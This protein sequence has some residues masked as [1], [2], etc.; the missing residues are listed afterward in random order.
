VE[1]QLYDSNGSRNAYCRPVSELAIQYFVT[2]VLDEFLKYRESPVSSQGAITS[3]L[4]ASCGAAL[5]DEI[6]ARDESVLLPQAHGFFCLALALPL[7][8]YIPQSATRVA[9]CKRDIAVLRSVLIAIS[10]RYG[11]GKLFLRMIDH[12]QSNVAKTARPSEAYDGVPEPTVSLEEHRLFPFPRTFC[13]NMDL[14]EPS[15]GVDDLFSLNNFALMPDDDA[16]FDFTWLDA[17]GL[18]LGNASWDISG[19]N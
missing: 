17:F 3:L 4:A 13:D 10:D 7:V 16:I 18:D 9:S 6:F 19:D 8:H 12:L 5:Y 11:D 1:L 15:V 14:L 2:I